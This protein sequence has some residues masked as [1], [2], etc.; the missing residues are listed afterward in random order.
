MGE[1][2]LSWSAPATGVTMQNGVQGADCRHWVH[3]GQRRH[4]TPEPCRRGP[5]CRPAL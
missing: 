1:V 2:A 3:G 5:P 4:D